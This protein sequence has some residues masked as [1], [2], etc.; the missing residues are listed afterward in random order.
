MD[1]VHESVDRGRRRST[2]DH[3]HCLRGSSPEN[4]RNGAPVCGTSPRL[5][6]KGKGTAVSLTNCKRGRRRVGHGWATVGTVKKRCQEV[7]PI[8]GTDVCRPR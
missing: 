1:Q 6:K 5:R 8:L 4:G 7:R 2:V 3:G